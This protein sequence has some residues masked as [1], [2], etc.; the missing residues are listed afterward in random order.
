MPRSASGLVDKT[1]H[2]HLTAVNPRYRC[3]VVRQFIYVESRPPVSPQRNSPS[4]RV[5]LVA[6]VDRQCRS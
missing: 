1:I 6:V 3:G 4:V 2:A 5:P